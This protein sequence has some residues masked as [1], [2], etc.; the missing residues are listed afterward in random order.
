[1]KYFTA[2]K[3]QIYQISMCEN[4][5]SLIKTYSVSSTVTRVLIDINYQ[6]CLSFRQIHLFLE[7]NLICIK[8]I[9]KLYEW[10]IF[11]FYLS[12]IIWIYRL[13]GGVPVGRYQNKSIF[14]FGW[15][16][17]NK[18]HAFDSF[19]FFIFISFVYIFFFLINL[20]KA[21]LFVIGKI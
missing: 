11:F 14:F 21:S 12:W 13:D 9:E 6:K 16:L 5:R 3:D 15:H 17:S 8:T 2:L 4:N 20:I 18:I 1:M 10:Y 19:S 7:W